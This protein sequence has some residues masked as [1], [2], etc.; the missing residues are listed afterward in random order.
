MLSYEITGIRYTT[1]VASF[2]GVP[3][4][5]LMFNDL[6]FLNTYVYV[7]T[8]YVIICTIK[9]FFFKKKKKLS[10]IYS[11]FTLLLKILQYFD[12]VSIVHS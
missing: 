12:V 2:C 1:T 9:I 11:I 10:F 8:Y 7:L 3:R 4:V 6:L 5:I